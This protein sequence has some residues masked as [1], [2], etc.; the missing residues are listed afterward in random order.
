MTLYDLFKLVSRELKR[1]ALWIFSALGYPLK[2]IFVNGEK[3]VEERLVSKVLK[4]IE[5]RKERYPLQYLLGKTEF[6]GEEY[7]LS[8]GTFVPREDSEILV[9]FALKVRQEKGWI[10]DLGCGVGNLLLSFLVHSPK[11]RGI[12]VDILPSSI[13]WSRKNAEN[14]GLEN[15]ASFYLM[16][17]FIFLEKF[18]GIFDLIVSNPPYIPSTDKDNLPP[19]VLREPE[20]TWLGGSKGMEFYEKIIE[21]GRRI[22]RKD[23]YIILEIGTKN[24]AERIKG[25]FKKRGYREWGTEKD[26]FGL[27]RLVWGKK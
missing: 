8:E 22:L 9:N 25:F 6:H 3:D 17:M 12:G 21:K 11:W 18:C 20:I 15:R 23:G 5:K 24:Q 19:E 27:E 26:Y 16:D 2:Q 7:F 4:I 13:Y 10:V 14:L 1:E